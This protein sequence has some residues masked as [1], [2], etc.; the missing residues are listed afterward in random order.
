MGSKFGIMGQ[1]SSKGRRKFRTMGRIFL[2]KGKKFLIKG[3]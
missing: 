2:I 3:K 1:Y